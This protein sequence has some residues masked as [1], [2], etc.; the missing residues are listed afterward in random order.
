[1]KT[2]TLSA[3]KEL[4]KELADK[5]AIIKD[6]VKDIKNKANQEKNKKLK[7][8]WFSMIDYFNTVLR[9]TKGQVDKGWMSEEQALIKYEE[10]I[11]NFNITKKAKEVNK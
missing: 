2:L 3:K 4:V 11:K 9:L 6:F 10:V 5:E 7:A 8:S 1:M